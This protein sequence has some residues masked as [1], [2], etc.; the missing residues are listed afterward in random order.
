MIDMRAK[1]ILAIV[2]LVALAACITLLPGS[3]SASDELQGD[4]L[5]DHGNGSTEWVGT[6]AS[7]T[8]SSTVINTLSDA[9]FSAVIADGKITI[10]GLTSRTIGGADTGG[11]VS[12]PGSTGV[13]VES[14]WTLYS[15]SNN[16]SSWTVID[17]AEYDSPYS[18]NKLAVGFYPNG[19][20]PTVN[21]EYKTAWTMFAGDSENS[22]N[23]T[24]GDTTEES[25]PL[26]HTHGD[27]SQMS[28][29]GCYCG[30]L[31]AD[32]MA[33]VKT[34][35][36]LTCYDIR[37]GHTIWDFKY[38]SIQIEMACPVIAGGKVYLPTTAGQ[39]YSFDIHEGPGVNDKN[40]IKSE[41]I[42]EETIELDFYSS[43]GRGPAAIVF[44]SGCIFLK[45]HNGMVYCFNSELE[46]VWSYQ[47][48]G[49]AY[50]TP[51]TVIDDYVFA[52]T[53]DGCL[54]IL[55][56]ADGTL[57][58]K[59]VVFQAEDPNTGKLIGACNV[60][61]PI[62]YDGGYYLFMTY[63]DGLGM[64]SK[65]A[66]LA[67]Y[68]YETSTNTLTKLKDLAGESNFGFTCNMVTR[69]VTDDFK[70]V[71]SATNKGIFKVDLEGNATLLS[72]IVGFSRETHATPT[73]VNN[74]L[75]YASTYATRELYELNVDGEV[76]GRYSFDNKWYAMAIVTVVD[77]YIVRSDDNGVTAFSGSKLDQY[78]PPEYSE[79]TPLWQILVIVLAAIAV[80]LAVVWIVLKFIVKWDKPFKEIHK[81]VM[82]YFFGENYSHNTKSKRKL[83]AV[84][85]IG[86]LITFILA[87]TSLCIGVKT[88]LSVVEAI[89]AVFSSIEKGGH[90]L[91]YEEMLIY[92]QR[93]PRA[94]ATI[95]VGIGLSVAGAMYQAV[96]KNP[97]VEPYIMG[98]SSGA[99]TLAVAVIVTDFTFFG[100]FSSSNIYLIAISAIIGGLFAF[101]CTLLLA[102]K[103]GGK[104]INFVLAGIVIGL[105]FSAI[106]SIMMI[107]SGTKI[108]HALSWLYG[109]F[110]SITWNELWLVLI[111]CIT[112]SM[113]PLIWARELNLVLLGDDQAMQMGLN[114]K[115][116]NRM[117]LIIASILTAF[118]VA[119]CGIIG[120]VGLVVPHVARMIMGGDHRLMLPV[121]M[122]FGGS[123]MIV[124]DL[125]SRAL[126][127]GFELPVGAVT[128]IIGVP[129]FAYL[130]I[131]SRGKY[132]A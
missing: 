62:R 87:L 86:S 43:Y 113:I 20:T 38:K 6:H 132:D 110:A 107:Q 117:I 118:C 17:P 58:K 73:L 8:I 34:G 75:L 30:T 67:L 21:P 42:P 121:T 74:E 3:D 76:V 102:E 80:I 123:L 4:F 81:R 36:L 50:Y 2:S 31:Y 124:A 14:H 109:S 56:S 37:T 83:Y 60:P 125:L 128:T 61:S 131:R 108:A 66:S 101:G 94:I 29:Y 24:V 49:Q 92:N 48:G 72:P 55:N 90:G 122:A 27:G 104:S 99:G 40:V 39:I 129:V 15:W 96:I 28:A 105:V 111:P 97:L 71:F 115:R 127:T 7:N 12:E 1:V 33:I 95:A 16:T 98:V 53:Y 70:G 130:L 57:I 84:I 54:Y 68:K 32:G 119:F 59:E 100:L 45:A 91:T 88:N 120:F 77:N 64:N 52:G 89:S 126:L 35:G 69:Y 78:V 85:I 19:M 18:G 13:K 79:P 10:D 26:W 47:M 23:Q 82:T 93:L 65:I 46:L 25:I 106:Q 112:L 44:N 9:S 114:V 11:S 63:S 5:I 22:V 116:F 103:T 41:D 51:L